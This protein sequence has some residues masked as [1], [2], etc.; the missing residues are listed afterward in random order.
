MEKCACG[1]LSDRM[2]GRLS[3]TA[4]GRLGKRCLRAVHVMTEGFYECPVYPA[5]PPCG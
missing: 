4:T 5:L 3:G 1:A 2:A